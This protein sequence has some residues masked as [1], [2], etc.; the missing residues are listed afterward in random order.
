MT[1]LA[2]LLALSPEPAARAAAWSVGHPEIADDL[3][4]VCHRESRCKRIGVHKGDSHGSRG[5]WL[6]QTRV[7]H[8]DKA[9][10]PYGDGGWATR[11]AFG[12]SAAAH[13]EYMPP[14]YSKRAL[15][16]PIVSAM[17][18]ARKYLAKCV[19]KRRSSWCPRGG[20]RA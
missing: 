1:T 2:I 14:C 16:I 12:L 17:V 9:C 15:D 6:Y 3:V 5:A 20:R 11:G 10:Q 8:L 13:H 19:G 7:G 18:A 4:R